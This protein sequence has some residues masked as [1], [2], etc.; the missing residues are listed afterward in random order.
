MINNNIINDASIYPNFNEIIKNNFNM[1]VKQFISDIYKYITPRNFKFLYNNS[2]YKNFII[3][4]FSSY[5]IIFSLLNN[6]NKD[7]LE[8]FM[9]N[10]KMYKFD[11]P[12][13]LEHFNNS[14]NIII[15]FKHS[16]TII[17]DLYKLF[18]LS[19]TQINQIIDKC[20]N[21]LDSDYFK[22]IKNL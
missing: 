2:N 6:R 11:N 16:R 19:D 5:N 14:F 3:H 12:N 13:I 7:M 4:I 20:I 18:N 21:D 15:D 10:Y 22:L 1:E 8:F 9:L 17:I